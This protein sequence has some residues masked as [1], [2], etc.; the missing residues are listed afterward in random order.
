MDCAVQLTQCLQHRM[1]DTN[2]G[3]MLAVDT[4]VILSI[5]KGEDQ[6]ALWLA[7]LQDEAST[8]D[9]VA[10]AVVWSEVRAFFGNHRDC[11]MAFDALKIGFGAIDESAALLAGDIFRQYRKAGGSRSAVLP[12]FLV[13]AH[14]AIHATALA[15]TDRGYFRQYFPKLNILSL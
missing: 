12:D 9:L 14:A 8:R 4:S 1:G 13:A 3:T 5:L 2:P 7:R 15:T 11:Q 6:G 10:S